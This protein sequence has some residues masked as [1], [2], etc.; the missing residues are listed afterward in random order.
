[1]IVLMMSVDKN[2]GNGEW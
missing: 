1:M 2:G